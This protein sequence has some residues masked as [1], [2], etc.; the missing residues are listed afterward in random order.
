[1]LRGIAIGRPVKRRPA[2]ETPAQGLGQCATAWPA[3]PDRLR[4]PGGLSSRKFAFFTVLMTG[5]LMITGSTDVRRNIRLVVLLCG[6]VAAVA[7]LGWLRLRPSRFGE[8]VYRIGWMISPPFQ[9]RGADGNAAGLSVDLLNEAARR[10]GIALQWIFWPDSSESALKTK[11]VDLWPLITITPERLKDFY[12]SE[13]YLQHEHCL[14]VRDESPY[15]KIEDLATSTVGIANAAID[16]VHL[17]QILP[18]A[19]PLYRPRIGSVIDDICAGR[20]QAALMDKYTA[21]STLLEMHGCGGAAL[22]WIAVPQVRSQL[23]V[24]ATF[25]NRA[26]ADAIREEIGALGQEGRLAAIFGQFGFMS[27]QDVESVEALVDARRRESRLLIA[28][29]MFAF[30]FALTCWQTVRL[31]R[32]RNRTHEAEAKLCESQQ[33]NLQ[34]QKLESIG[35][36]AG[37]VAHDF[38]NLLTVINGYSSIVFNKLAE[39]DPLRAPVKEIRKAGDRAAD[40][41]QQ[42]LA[43]GRKQMTR[44]QPVSLNSV[45]QESETMFR[46]LL[47]EDI[48]FTT[49]LNP[50][51]G[52]VNA[53][54]AQIHQVLMNLVIN[55]RDAMPDGGKLVIETAPVQI[56][57]QYAAEHPQASPGSAI[58]LTVTDTGHGM[59]EQTKEHI[60]EPFFT[61]KGM[62]QGTGLGL[63]TVYG[64][65]QQSNGWIGV[66]S[67]PGEGS[68][69]EIYLPRITGARGADVR[70]SIDPV[71]AGGSETILVVEDQAEVRTFAVNAL[72]TCG[73]RVLD[74]ADGAQALSL[75]ARHPGP[76]HVL[77]TDVVLPG[78]NGRELA[79]R[80]RARRPDV[81]VVFT[82]GYTD[83]VIAHRGVLDKDV[84]FIPK[85]YTTHE[86]VAKVREVLKKADKAGA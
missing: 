9:V 75:C 40:L 63:A 78:I 53:D 49:N 35:R 17:H 10:R 66:R 82:S 74:A 72:T 29:A 54:P 65:V 57:A 71:T 76:I 28:T 3:V 31:I 84:A 70:A 73:Y 19:E 77:L 22:R 61:T 52:L 44:P 24:G 26:A 50:E 5:T 45:V 60:F 25:E 13:P 43:F 18:K 48:E 39:S 12:I 11:V 83:D 55:A 33:R 36:L 59:D 7:V 41:T 85:P 86:V 27:G 51:L 38:N 14:L 2:K 37:G 69:F 80:V 46:R 67:A 20:T 62:A 81:V 56:D 1:M 34:A 23:G 68:S 42:L 79:D 47:G 16:T 58:R 64:V 6:I 32:E 15:R 4:H 8:R 30:L 21:I